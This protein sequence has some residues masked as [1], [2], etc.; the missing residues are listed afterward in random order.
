MYRVKSSVIPTNSADDSLHGKLGMPG[1]F[2]LFKFEKLNEA[3][4]ETMGLRYE[5]RLVV[6][7]EALAKYPNIKHSG[8]IMLLAEELEEV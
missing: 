1:V 6:T 2:K 3:I 7:D 4:H 8:T 5:A